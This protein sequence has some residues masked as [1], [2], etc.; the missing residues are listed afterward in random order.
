MRVAIA[1]AT[2]VLVI[3]WRGAERHF[4]RLLHET[5]RHSTP[6]TVVA[7]SED[8]AKHTVDQLWPTSKFNR[9]RLLGSCFSGLFSARPG[10]SEAAIDLV[11]AGKA[12]WVE[13]DPE[14][15]DFSEEPIEHVD[16][17]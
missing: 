11:L 8:A 4:L 7:E 16:L 5:I 13:R 3:G 9:Y 17:P 15:G 14:V 1:E 10:E 2:E 6:V 12:P